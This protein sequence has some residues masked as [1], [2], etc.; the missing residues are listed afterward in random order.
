MN[1]LWKQLAVMCRCVEL[2]HFCGVSSTV[3]AASLERA[4]ARALPLGGESAALT[5]EDTVLGLFTMLERVGP[6]SIGWV[7]AVV[8]N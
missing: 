4:N 3:D 1:K 6:V 7:S 8:L 2:Q 5:M